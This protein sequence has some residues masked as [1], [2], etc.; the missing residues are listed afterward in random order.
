MPTKKVA[1]KAAK[2]ATKKVAKKAA[3]KTAVKKAAAP[4]P[5][6]KKGDYNL[7]V[8]TKGEVFEF[9]AVDNIAE[10]LM[11]TGVKFTNTKTLFT[12]TKGK[13][14]RVVSHFRP[15]ALRILKNPIAART[16]ERNVKAYFGEKRK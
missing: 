12:V 10:C 6:T 13:K 4:K 9:K 1:R 3:R 15:Q 16:F 2:K 5:K 14:E 7:K 8:E 11:S